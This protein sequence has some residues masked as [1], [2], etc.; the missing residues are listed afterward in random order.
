MPKKFSINP[1]TGKSNRPRRKQTKKFGPIRPPNLRK[2]KPFPY[3]KLGKAIGN[4]LFG[5]RGGKIGSSVGSLVSKI[6]GSGDYKINGNSL[7]TG[8]TPVF[9][10]SGRDTIISHREFIA[11][12]NGTTNFSLASYPINPGMGMTFPWLSAVASNF[13][14]Y[15]MLGLIFEYRPTSGTAVGNTNTA[16]GT[17]VLATDYDAAHPSFISKQQMESYEFSCADVP[18]HK[19]IHPVECAPK[20]K[21]IR[22]QYVRTGALSVGE[23]VQF[24]DLG[25][26]QIATTGMQAGV[27]TIGELWVSYHVRLLKPRLEI[28]LNATAKYSHIAEFAAATATT[29]APLGLAGGITSPSSNL[30]G[31]LSIT[32]VSFVMAQPGNYLISARFRS[33]TNLTS[34]P[35]LAFGANIVAFNGYEVGTA[36]SVSSSILLFASMIY[37]VTVNAVGTAAANTVTIA[38]PATYA[39][40]HTDIIIQLLPSVPAI[41]F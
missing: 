35:S 25:N 1:F 37:L 9:S 10:T 2:P 18:F 4:N 30:P 34:N 27:T 12:I 6:Y 33:A 5:P 41:G 11:D 26:F 22:V 39:A 21:T 20:E 17:V 29:A 15:E 28:P 13:E 38:G 3:A 32:T 24:Y 16:L 7:T 8:M 19:I 31:I 40:G 36:S 14:Q 23:D